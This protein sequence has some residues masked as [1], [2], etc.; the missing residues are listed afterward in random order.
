MPNDPTFV[1]V[2]IFNHDLTQVLLILK[3]RP[4]WQAGFFNG[5]GGKLEAGETALQCAWREIREESTLDI[6]EEDWVEVGVIKQPQGDVAV[7]TTRYESAMND[8]RTNEDEPIEWHPSDC[9]PNNVIA[10]LR[11]LIPLCQEKL[12]TNFQSFSISYE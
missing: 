12:E 10:N 5:L 4:A 6:R 8:A 3:N 1:V 7:L 2:F 9:M 11:W